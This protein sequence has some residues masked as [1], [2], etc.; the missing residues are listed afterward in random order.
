[1]AP[2]NY[3]TAYNV[4]CTGCV[5]EAFARQLVVQVEDQAEL[6]GDERRAIAYV[7]RRLQ[8]IAGRT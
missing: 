2:E 7:N 6:E 1:M 4:S 3:A 8:S 5:T